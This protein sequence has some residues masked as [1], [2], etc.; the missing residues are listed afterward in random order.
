MGGRTRHFGRVLR[1]HAVG[2]H[3]IVSRDAVSH[4][5]AGSYHEAYQVAFEEAYAETY[6][7]SNEGSYPSETDE[8]TD[9]RAHYRLFRLQMAHVNRSR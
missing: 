8:S 7:A 5:S 3:R 6:Q 1:D 2:E 4:G 9:A